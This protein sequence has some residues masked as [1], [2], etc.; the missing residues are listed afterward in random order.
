MSVALDIIN[1]GWSMINIRDE[2][3]IQLTRQ[4]TENKNEYVS[5]LSLSYVH[6]D[7][8]NSVRSNTLIKILISPDPPF[9]LQPG[10]REI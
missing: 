1:K 7:R 2:I 8:R 10:I 3:Y 6:R 9:T 5:C 4:T